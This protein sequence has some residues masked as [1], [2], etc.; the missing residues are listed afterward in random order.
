MTQKSQAALNIAATWPVFPCNPLDKKPLT[1][2]GFKDASRDITTIDA[3]WDKWPNAMIG[4]PMGAASGIWAV[5]PDVPENSLQP[6]GVKAWQD[7]IN[8]HGIPLTRVH[9]TPSG[10]K[11]FLFVWH[12]ETPVRNGTG[13]LPKGIDVRG[14]G[15]YI[16][17]PPSV[18]ADGKGYTA[19]E[20][21]VIAEAPQW[22]YTMILGNHKTDSEFEARM[23]EDAGM[24][25]GKDRGY[26]PA[27]PMM[28]EEALNAL[29]SDDYDSWFRIA[30]ALRRELGDSGKS[31]FHKWSSRSKKYDPRA[32]DKKWED[33]ADV[34]RITA[35]T[36]FYMA[37]QVDT[38][39]RDRYNDRLRKQ[40]FGEQKQGQK[41]E[42]KTG[43]KAYMARFID[44]SQWDNVPVPEQEWA[45]PDR[46][47][48]RRVTLFSG[49]GAAGKSLLQLQLSVA[50]VIG[51]EWL[52]TIPKQGPVIFFDA[53]DESAVIHKRMADVLRHY[54]VKFK[55]VK[56]KLH[57]MSMAGENALLAQAK[58]KA[59]IMQPTD[60]YNEMLEMC[61][62]IKPVM[63]GIASSAD[64]YAGSEIDRSQVRQFMTLLT[65]MAM[66]ANGAVCLISHP[67]LTGMANQSGISGSTAWHNSARARIFLKTTN[68]IDSGIRE[69]EFAKNNY[70][71]VSATVT[72]QYKDGL[73]L[74]LTGEGGA[75]ISKLAMAKEIFVRILQRY[76]VPVGPKKG[77][78]YAP[79]QFAE[80]PEAK[81]AA[82]DSKI[83]GDA[84][85]ALI[86]EGVVLVEM[87]GKVST[88]QHERLVLNP[89]KLRA[90][91]DQDEMPF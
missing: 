33:A 3:W 4:V 62:D 35:G 25:V 1:T 59:G 79:A 42:Q 18:M 38:D 39:W 12:P 69:V 32:C 5:D 11:H 86:Q 66:A 84:M 20:V 87:Y 23:R 81:K 70:G 57:V 56:D 67:S 61:A 21:K 43:A 50:H 68:I 65:R 63:I 26:A 2:H 22:L 9:R 60:L 34:T 28:I 36:L 90:E 6:D 82:C 41:Q 53:E 16:V 44:Y 15:G 85:R 19:N 52:G 73:F 54:N 77:T 55:D 48:I 8:M 17:V 88:R 30:G 49:T 46:V 51:K 75:I 72:V 29:S 71:P 10:G 7:L 91:E 89:A 31:M 47:P 80:E 45:V 64:V 58:G 78:S 13:I 14:E 37:D 40:Q 83:L 74:P 27:D 76:T 24:G